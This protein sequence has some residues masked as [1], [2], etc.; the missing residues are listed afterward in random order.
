MS[1]VTAK[2]HID[3]AYRILTGEVYR[4][5]GPEN[6]KAVNGMCV[7][8]I[9]LQRVDCAIGPKGHSMFAKLADQ[10]QAAYV[11]ITAA[12]KA[13]EGEKS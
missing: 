11:E 5:T 13:F 7:T 12:K 10:I 3:E 1:V 8:V 2:S 9:E 4:G 6:M